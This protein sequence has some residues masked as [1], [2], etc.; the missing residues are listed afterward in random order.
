MKILLLG[1]Y[2][3][4]HNNLRKALK[5]EGHEVKLVSDGD[6]Y[7]CLDSDVFIKYERKAST[8][9]LSKI[10]RILLLYSGFQGSIQ[11]FKHIQ[12]L[13]EFKGYDVVQLINPIFLNEFGPIVNFFVFKYI[14]KNNKKVFLSALGDDYFWIK[15]CLDRNFEYSMFDDLS[16]KSI[17][18]YIYPLSY[19][20]GF[21]NPFLNRYI[22]KNVN[23]IIPGLYDY[24]A[25]Y[26]QFE[27]C[28]DIV[29]LIVDDVEKDIEIVKQFRYPIKIFHGWQPNKESRKG[30]DVF[31][32][33]IKSLIKK[34]PNKIDYK[35]VAGVPY[36]EYINSFNEA[37]IFIDQCFSQDKGINALLGMKSGKVVFSGFEDKVKQYYHIE[38]EP[39]V[40]AIPNSD[41]IF[42]ELEHIVLNPSLI[43]KYSLKARKYIEKF[44]NS[45]Y[46]L[47]KYFKIWKEY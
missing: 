18:R 5:Q 31:D 19:V 12:T 9:K 29:P 41:S 3:G 27:N 28:T 46:V 44:H 39:L 35:I 21:F 42:E 32:K 26:K 25:A 8:N 2:S 4:A 11:I 38:D 34:Y 16:L 20:Y 7:K 37:D 1:E 13:K 23:A 43:P 36:S 17:K 40:N 24:Y 45:K 22:A 14:R 15:Y 6:G 10:S 30:N 33:A 47:E